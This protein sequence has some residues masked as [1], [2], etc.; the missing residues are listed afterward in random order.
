MVKVDYK[1]HKYKILHHQVLH[2]F[3]K[4]LQPQENKMHFEHQLKTRVQIVESKKYKK[5]KYK[6]DLFD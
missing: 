4:V 1:V 3:L 5:P 6:K 2:M